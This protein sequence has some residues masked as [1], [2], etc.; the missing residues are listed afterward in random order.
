MKVWMYL[1]LIL[2]DFS[3]IIIIGRKGKEDMKIIVKLIIIL[4]DIRLIDN[5][6]PFRINIDRKTYEV[7][8]EMASFI[9]SQHNYL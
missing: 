5:M 8:S 2:F 9:L 6:D 4:A 3:N 7:I 1:T